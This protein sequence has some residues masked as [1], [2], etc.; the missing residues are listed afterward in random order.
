MALKFGEVGKKGTVKNKNQW[1][2]AELLPYVESIRT[3]GP[4]DRQTD[5]WVF[6]SSLLT[7]ESPWE[8]SSLC[9]YRFSLSQP[10]YFL[11]SFT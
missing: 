3:F 8:W 9:C 7:L 6:G 11:N 10:R 5:R 1:Y 2:D 4:M